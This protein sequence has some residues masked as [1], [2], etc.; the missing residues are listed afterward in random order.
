MRLTDTAETVELQLLHPYTGS[1]VQPHFPN[2]EKI[3]TESGDRE[4][5]C[6]CDIRRPSKIGGCCP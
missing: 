4:T 1:S 6:I 2:T 5:A 3:I